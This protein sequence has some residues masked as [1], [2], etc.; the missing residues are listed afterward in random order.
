MH[1]TL[2]AQLLQ[3]VRVGPS[4]HIFCLANNCAKTSRYSP[5][6]YCFIDSGNRRFTPLSHDADVASNHRPIV[7]L[8]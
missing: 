6:I 4:C 8:V 5:S 1:Q 2:S 7:P 3:E